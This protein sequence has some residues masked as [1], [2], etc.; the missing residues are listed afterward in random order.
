M[1]TSLRSRVLALVVA[2]A[3][4]L[5]AA[6]TTAGAVTNIVH[7]P[8]RVISH[9][10]SHN[11][12]GYATTSGTYNS[13]S[14]SWVQPT[15][16]CGSGATWSAFWV[17][18]DGYKSDTVEQT[19]SEADCNAGRKYSAWYEMYPANPVTFSNTVSPGDQFT[20]SVTA[21][22]DNF[23]LTISDITQGWT[24]TID[25][26][27]KGAKKSSAEVIAEA[28]CC[29]DDGDILPLTDFGTVHFSDAMAN[30]EPIGDSPHT[31]INMRPG[32]EGPNTDNC[33][34]LT[35]DENF[36]CTF[37]SN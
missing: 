23:T 13:V 25:K 31:V 30:G 3:L 32:V 27:L 29:Q 17:G 22:G 4:G 6:P 10:T 14:A 2:P 8:L 35:S 9:T 1:K 26:S 19:G 34:K 24:H 37:V 36:S 15:A 33:S 28:P 16:H 12:S 11:W 20:A 21:S 5:L 7:A 18:I